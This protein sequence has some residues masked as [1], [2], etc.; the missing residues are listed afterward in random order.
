L[1]LVAFV[2][3]GIVAFLATDGH[4][5]VQTAGASAAA[6]R[7][8]AQIALPRAATPSPSAH[9]EPATPS[10]RLDDLPVESPRKR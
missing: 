7:V 6:G 4:A 2:L 1:G 10:V 5:D 9:G 3:G 8:E